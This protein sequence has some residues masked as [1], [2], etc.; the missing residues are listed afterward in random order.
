VG[1]KLPTILGGG[2]ERGFVRGTV[3]AQV[4]MNLPF[5][6]VSVLLRMHIRPLRGLSSN[7]IILRCMA[8]RIVDGLYLGSWDDAND[9]VRS[10]KATL[11]FSV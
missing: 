9:E 2:K 7:R 8:S 4:G 6:K 3:L 10:L 5:E 1:E 11:C